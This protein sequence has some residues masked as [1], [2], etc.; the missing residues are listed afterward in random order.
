MPNDIRAQQ[1]LKIIEERNI[2]YLV[3]FTHIDNLDSILKH[4]LVPR[5]KV[6]DLSIDIFYNDEFRYDDAEDANCLSISFPNYKMFYTCRDGVSS[7]ENWVVLVFDAKLLVEKDCA[8]CYT[9]A[10]SDEITSIDLEVRKSVKALE[11]MYYD[12]RCDGVSRKDLKITD[13]CPTDPQA[14]VLLFDTIEPSDIL[15]VVT[16][17]QRETKELTKMYPEIDIQCIPKLF[18][19]R[20]DFDYWRQ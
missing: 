1:I 8:F 16:Y 17:S 12:P 9:N 3:H 15:A 6:D 11:D 10:A 2:K 14:E 4:G 19:Y 13:R 5:S 18:K 7:G 20:H